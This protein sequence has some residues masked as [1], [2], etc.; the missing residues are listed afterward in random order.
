[1]LDLYQLSWK[2][3]VFVGCPP[4]RNR[5]SGVIWL[6]LLIQEIRA[7]HVQHWIQ[8]A[9]TNTF[10]FYIICLIYLYTLTLSYAQ[11]WQGS[12][13]DDLEIESL[14][15]KWHIIA[16]NI[17]YKNDNAYKYL[18]ADVIAVTHLDERI[19]LPIY[20]TTLEHKE[21]HSR[22]WNE[23]FSNNKS[24]SL[25]FF[26]QIDLPNLYLVTQTLWVRAT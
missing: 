24:T 3:V 7:A 13:F 21:I 23:D 9:V 14:H 26:I 11:R 25:S 4:A 2:W 12:Y 10:S 16:E 19:M 8:S 18:K 20:S 1:M 5:K 22:L 6:P 17:A 15:S